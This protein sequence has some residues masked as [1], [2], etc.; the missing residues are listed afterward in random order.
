M[1]P[2]RRGAP[3]ASSSRTNTESRQKSKFQKT[4]QSSESNAVPGVQKIKAAL[5]QTRRLLAKDN[6]A[7]DVRVSTERRLKA[8]EAELV[9][10]ER[11]RKE[12]TLAMRYHKI[13]F[14]ERQKVTRKLNQVKKQLETSADKKERKKLEKSLKE[15]RVDLNYIIHYPKLKKYISLFPPEA[16]QVADDDLS[17]KGKEKDTTNESSQTDMQREEIRRDIQ[18]RMKTGQ[19][20]SEP[21]LEDRSEHGTTG[22]PKAQPSRKAAAKSAN[23]ESEKHVPKIEDDA[24]FGEESE[25]SEAGEDNS[26]DDKMDES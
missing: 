18:E 8:L 1:A 7:A 14:F 21:E 10:A 22:R 19:L 16:R 25:E 17:A 13:K 23:S 5:R 24:F 11:V 12:R 4:G 26:E 15:L 3:Y 9:E 6:L 20:S 2:V